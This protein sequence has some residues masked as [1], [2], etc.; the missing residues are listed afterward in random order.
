MIILLCNDDGYNSIGITLLADMLK[1]YGIVVIVAP[2]NAMSAKSISITLG[3]SIEVKK[4]SENVY[5]VDGTPA[6]AVAFGLSSLNTKF[7]LVVSGC[8]NGWNI[9]YDTMYSGTIGVCLQALTYVI[10]AIAVSCEGNFEILEKGFDKVMKYIFDNKLLSTEYLLNVNFPLGNE[11]EDIRM[12]SL[13]YRKQTTY[14]IHESGDNYIAYRELH[15]E[16]C[17]QRDTD[18]YAVMHKQVSITKLNKTLFMKEAN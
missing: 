16:E 2:K 14:F 3:R 12:T 6:D 15:D 13:Y 11:I 9:S 17:E 1:K 7:D 5:S 18:V 4:I 10:P 8:N